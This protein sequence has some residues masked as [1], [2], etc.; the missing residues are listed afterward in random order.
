ME[1]SGSAAILAAGG[2][3]ARAPRGGWRHLL[4][5]RRYQHS[6]GKAKMTDNVENLILEHL[7]ALRSGQDW[8]EHIKARLYRIEQ[9]LDLR[10]EA[11]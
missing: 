2:R 9:R 10:D 4:R 5:I 7:R 8:I 11:D 1:Q 3:D 6:Y